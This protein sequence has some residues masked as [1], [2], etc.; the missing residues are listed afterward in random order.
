[1]PSP[2]LDRLCG[3]GLLHAEPS[4]ADEYAGLLRSDLPDIDERFVT[5]L[6][7]AC[8][9]VAAKITA[10]PPPTPNSDTPQTLGGAG[11]LN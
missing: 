7:A 8:A 11:T 2:H 9:Q 1:M 3:A 5:D 10:L 6:V 4:A